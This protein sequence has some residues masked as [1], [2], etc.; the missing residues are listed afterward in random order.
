MIDDHMPESWQALQDGVK[1]IFRNIGLSAEVEVDIETPRGSVNIDVVAVDLRSVDQIKYLVECKNWGSAIPQHVVHSFTTIIHETGA[2]IG[3]IISKNGLQSGA[4]RYTQSTN[5][6]GMTYLEFQKRY[7]AV[8]WKRYFCPRIGDAADRP[9]QYVEECNGHRDKAYAG[10]SPDK[11]QEFDKLRRTYMAAIMVFSMFNVSTLSD[12]FGTS[13]IDTPPAD[14][15]S[16][17]KDMLALIAPYIT[18]HCSTFRGLLEL[19]L[20][21]LTDVEEQFNALF[22]EYIF[23]LEPISM[24]T[25]DG[26]PLHDRWAKRI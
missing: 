4:E 9:L 17:K 13:K 23:N 3:F 6:T 19:I 11:Q 20:K 5:I 7:F 24:V 21:F 1:R 26:P 18:W 8:W 12:C 2:N 14:L 25:E 15:E 10:L 22:G 16:F